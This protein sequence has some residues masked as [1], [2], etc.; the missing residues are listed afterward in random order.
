MIPF[1][2]LQERQ[3]DLGKNL[4]IILAVQC[5]LPPQEHLAWSTFLQEGLELV[6]VCWMAVLKESVAWQLLFK[7]LS[8]F[9]AEQGGADSWGQSSISQA[10]AIC[11]W[12]ADRK[13]LE[14]S[15]A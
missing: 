4:M 13:Y 10:G 8:H 12:T 9:C 15:K 1:L 14:V 11:L 6:A 5:S 3:Q 7:Q 2:T